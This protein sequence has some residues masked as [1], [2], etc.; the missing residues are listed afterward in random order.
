MRILLISPSDSFF[1]NYS[2]SKKSV[3]VALPL[4]AAYTPREHDV[5]VADQGYGD[6]VYHEGIDLVGISAMTAQAYQGYKIAKYYKERG[7]KVVMGGIHASV[8]PEEAAGH[9]DAVCVG[10]ADSLWGQIL[11]DAA[12]NRLKKIYKSQ[13]LFPMEEVPHLRSDLIR[14]K[15]TSFSHT[16][17]QASRGCPYNCEFCITSA[18]FGRKFRFRPVDHVID[19]I[20]RSK[21]KLIFFVDDNIFGSPAYSEELF[22]KLLPLKLQWC[23]QAS[24]HT[25]TRDLGLLKL[26]KKSGALGFFMGLESV[27]ELSR[28]I[29]TSGAK[30][31]TST[32]SEISKKIRLVLGHRILVHTSIIFGLDGDGPMVFEKTVDFLKT[33]SVFIS[34]FCILTPYPGT[35]IYQRFKEEGRL[36]H[37]DWSRYSNENVVFTPKLMTPQQLKDGSDWAGRALYTWPSIIKRS[38]SNWHHPIYYSVLNV[39]TRWANHTNHGPGSIISMNRLDKEDWLKS[40]MTAKGVN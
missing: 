22:K 30:L 2:R 27:N 28:Q 37:E 4:L 12:A 9:V 16:V 15:R 18:M 26:A 1:V 32:L 40:C 11:E 14:R 6:N 20:K 8:L 7:V 34:S 24:L 21:G 13:D 33:N 19:E 10:E 3:C 31:G 5:I 36:L 29:S 23:G 25:L 38:F 17:I 35:R 39:Y